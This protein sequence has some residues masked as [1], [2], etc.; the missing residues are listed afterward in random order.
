MFKHMKVGTRL[1]AGF[2]A[3]TLLGALVAG[4]GI[5]NMSRINDSSDRLYQKE[6]LGI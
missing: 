3:L 2:L 6:L 1:I 5:F 4:I